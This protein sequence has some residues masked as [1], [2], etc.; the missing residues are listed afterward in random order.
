MNPAP[1]ALRP[2][3]CALHPAPGT[4]NPAV[5]SERGTPVGVGTGSISA[6]AS[7]VLNPEHSTSLWRRLSVECFGSSVWCWVFGRVNRIQGS[8]LRVE[9]SG[10][11]VAGQGGVPGAFQRQPRWCFAIDWSSW[12]SRTSFIRNRPTL[13]PYSR[14]MPRAL[15]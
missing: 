6:A 5:S 11:R 13:G 3:P 2:A 14:P 12:A 1:C 7:M 4:L 10:L 9:D 15:W 8:R